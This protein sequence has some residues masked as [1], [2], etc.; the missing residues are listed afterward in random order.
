MIA[1]I[2]ILS[3]F[4]NISNAQTTTETIPAQTCAACNLTPSTISQINTMTREL[5]WAIKT[6]GTEAPY[7]GQPVTPE[8][9]ESWKFSPPKTSILSKALRRA[10]A[11]L[12]SIL[13]LERIAINLDAYPV[14]RIADS[15]TILIKWKVYKRDWA[16]VDAITEE[17][18]N[19]KY[20]LSV[21]WWRN[22]YIK[23]VTLSKM[24]SILKTYKQSGILD[25]S[26]TIEEITYSD[27][28]WILENLN[29]LIKH[30]I[31]VPSSTNLQTNIVAGKSLI[32]ISDSAINDITAW[33][34]CLADVT[35]DNTR[36]QTRWELAKIRASTKWA[37]QKNIK[38]IWDSTT[39][40][41]NT[42][43]GIG[44]MVTDLFKSEAEKL[45]M[46]PEEYKQFKNR[47]WF[48]ATQ[49]KKGMFTGQ[50][51][52]RRSQRQNIKDGFTKLRRS[53]DGPATTIDTSAVQ[54]ITDPKERNFKI[55]MLTSVNSIL[56]EA[57]QEREYV[58]LA[59]NKD[60]TNRFISLDTQLNDLSKLMWEKS[61]DTSIIKN[62]WE[63]CTLQCSNITNKKCY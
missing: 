28:L 3:V 40:L 7:A 6:I 36:G 34:M 5:L 21:W 10:R 23:N 4:S 41:K 39:R 2:S 9:F 60:V 22:A 24:Q 14:M 44:T 43:A 48:T 1:G 46:S 20:A 54:N 38:D 8:W 27:L 25:S 59:E 53:S 57:N 30:Q 50:A 42:I 37:V 16:K 45:W 17:I 19:K 61:N 11:W 31:V 32:R 15:K 26:S 49:M 55:T 13:W 12:G 52:K 18:A 58:M 63:V 56:E 62:I 51:E 47:Y 33:Y 29:A 35:C